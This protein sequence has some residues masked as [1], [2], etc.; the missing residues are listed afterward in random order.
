M[1]WSR[2]CLLVQA[3]TGCF[4]RATIA[5]V[6]FARCG[7]C[8]RRNS[9][10]RTPFP[11]MPGQQARKW[12]FLVA[13]PVHIGGHYGLEAGPIPFEPLCRR[14]EAS[15]GPRPAVAGGFAGRTTPAGNQA[16]PATGPPWPSEGRCGNGFPADFLGL[17]EA[18]R[19]WPR[20]ACPSSPAWAT[21]TGNRGWKR[22]RAI[23]WPASRPVPWGQDESVMTVRRICSF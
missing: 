20:D 9:S 5:K 1:T 18:R 21:D 7:Q 17:C 16:K 13:G 22:S 14:R 12:G 10:I 23:G 4:P 3:G 19:S 15:H 2:R 11:V 8:Q 6:R